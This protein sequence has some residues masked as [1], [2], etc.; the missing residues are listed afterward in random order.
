MDM[1][2]LST[3][4]KNEIEARLDH[5][6]LNLDCPEF[7]NT[8]ASTEIFAWVIFGLLKPLLPAEHHLA[9]TLFETEINYVEI[10]SNFT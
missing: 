2:V 10:S 1:K 4:I 5:K 8:F 9:L 6:N 7:K 3:I